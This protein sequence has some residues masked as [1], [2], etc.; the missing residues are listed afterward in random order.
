M[1]G[2]VRRHDHL[3]DRRRRHPVD[4]S[5]EDQ[6]A[7]H[8]LLKKV[9]DSG[10]SLVSVGPSRVRP[11]EGTDE[12]EST[13]RNNQQSK[14]SKTNQ[15]GKEMTNE[16]PMD[17]KVL[18]STLWIFAMFNYLYADV[19][20][21]FF[22][23]VLQKELWQKFAGRIR[24]L[25]SHHPGIRV[26]NRG[27]DGN[28]DCHG[29]PVPGI[30]AQGESLGEHRLRRIPYAVRRLVADRRPGESFLCLFRSHRNGVHPAHRLAGNPVETD[31]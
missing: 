18:L 10:M 6:A 21:L 30:E 15:G 5:V 9:R 4:R 17:R 23:P 22:N 26:D 1:D 25:H 11:E 2:L 14:F 28:R 16:K 7:L 3:C 20:T 8:G 24:R 27:I 12:V 19:Y 29:H 13:S 31:G